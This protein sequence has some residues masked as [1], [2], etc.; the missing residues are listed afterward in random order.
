MAEF[1]RIPKYTK[2]ES[3]LIHQYTVAME[4]TLFILITLLKRERLHIFHDPPRQV[5][6]RLVAGL[7]R[8]VGVSPTEDKDLGP[9]PLGQGEDIDDG[10]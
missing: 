6:A 7:A 2:V 9:Q 4:V 5:W 1:D 3:T 10:E 8:E